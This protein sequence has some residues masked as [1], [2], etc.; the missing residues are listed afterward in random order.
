MT[1]SKFYLVCPRVLDGVDD[2]VR[3]FVFEDAAVLQNDLTLDATFCVFRRLDMNLKI[4]NKN[5]Q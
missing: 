1:S 2:N 4:E 5:I 3:R